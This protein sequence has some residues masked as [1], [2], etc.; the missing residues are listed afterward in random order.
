MYGGEI[1]KANTYFNI[2]AF[3]IFRQEKTLRRL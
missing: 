3:F 2:Y 1:R